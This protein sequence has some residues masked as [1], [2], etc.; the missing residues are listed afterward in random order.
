MARL[1]TCAGQVEKIGDFEHVVSKVEAERRVWRQKRTRMS[2]SIAATSFFVT[3][4]LI[5]VLLANSPG[6]ERAQQTFFS[7][8]YF[9]EALP[10][11][12]EGLWLN[13]RIL[14]FAAIVVGILAILLAAARSLRGAIFFPIRF[15]AAAYTDI[16]RGLPFIVV[17]Y[18]VGFGIPALNPQTRIPI[19][20]LGGFALVLTYTSY[21]SEVLRAGLEAIHPSQRAAARSLGLTHYQT[22]RHIVIPQAIRKVTP[23]LMNDFISMQKDVGLISTLGAMDAIRAAQVHQATTYNFTAYVVAGLLFILFA[24]PCIRLSDWYTARLQAREQI[25]GAF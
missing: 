22:L 11:V 17:L 16:F 25:G 2:I 4:V 23:A 5:A 18:L 24:W 14:F 3:V 20:L 19:A 10:K 1:V 6:W 13:I 7:G 15:L 8:K 12:A 9:L 21:V